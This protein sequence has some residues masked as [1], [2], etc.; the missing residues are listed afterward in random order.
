[1]SP[2][3]N[4]LVAAQQRLQQLQHELTATL[5]PLP[6]GVDPTEAWTDSRGREHQ[7]HDGWPTGTPERV[8]ALRE[9]I[10]QTSAA[11]G[12]H[13]YWSPLTG[14]ALVPARS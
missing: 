1:M 4:D 9:Q 7:A 13:E 3:S 6:I 10:R 11:I 8:E 12:S 5:A 2:Y 14:K